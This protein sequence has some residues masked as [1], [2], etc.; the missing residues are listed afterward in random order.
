ML[1]GVSVPIVFQTLTVRRA[2]IIQWWW[3]TWRLQRRGPVIQARATG[4][5]LCRHSLL[6]T[7]FETSWSS[8]DFLYDVM[9][10]LGQ[11]YLKYS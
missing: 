11:S 3:T 2:V 1:T 7:S 5:Q 6:W 8:L 4:K 10:S 9:M